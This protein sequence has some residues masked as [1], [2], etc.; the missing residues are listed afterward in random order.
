M[1][2]A[3]AACDAVAF[4]STWEG[5]G[6]PPIEAAIHRRPV[7][8]GPYP[9]AERAAAPSA[10]GGSTRRGPAALDAFLR[11][12]RRRRSTTT[13]RPARAAPR[14][15]PPRRGTSHDLAGRLGAVT[16]DEP[17]STP[18]ASA[19]RRI[20][21]WVA[22]GQRVGYG[23]FLAAIVLFVV[24]FAV[25]FD[26][27][28][29]PGDRRLPRRRLARARAGDR[30]RLRRQGGRAGGPRAGFVTGRAA[31]WHARVRQ[32]IQGEPWSPPQC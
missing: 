20:A 8:V 5:F 27:R 18:S 29:G 2:D 31:G 14:P 32:P 24:G 1:A 12:T 15:R 4:P 6:N 9:V 13:T 25:G 26:G 30:V 16:A 22:L 7:A 3:Y 28:V 11:R 17:A 10:S 21:R 23:L 19:G